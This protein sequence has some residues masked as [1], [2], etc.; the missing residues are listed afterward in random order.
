MRVERNE[1]KSS[2]IYAETQLREMKA[3]HDDVEQLFRREED[4]WTRRIDK[5]NSA[6][7]EQSESLDQVR[8]KNFLFARKPELLTIM[9]KTRF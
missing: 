7:S 2:A 3:K 6:K 9:I 4:E 1:L 5:A 8:V